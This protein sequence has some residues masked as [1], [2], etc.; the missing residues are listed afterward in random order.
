M[1]TFTIPTMS[2]LVDRL[3]EAIAR[4]E[5]EGDRYVLV[6]GSRSVTFTYDRAE[7]LLHYTNARLGR[8]CKR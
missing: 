7:K 3:D 8:A 4:A 1:A 6:E 5:D 2:A